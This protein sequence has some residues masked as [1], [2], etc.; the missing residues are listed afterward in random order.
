M[1]Q[2]GNIA[3]ARPLLER[4]ARE[5]SAEAAALLGASFDADWLK[6]SGA[7]GISG[8]AA[9]ATR[10]FEE[11]RRMGAADVERIIAGL[12]RR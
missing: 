2:S 11:A 3:V 10:W 5:G 8:D 9:T 12:S 6:R 4:A 7:L 1:L